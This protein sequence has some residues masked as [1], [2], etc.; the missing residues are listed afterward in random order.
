MKRCWQKVVA[1]LGMAWLYF[2]PLHAQT[3]DR[4]VQSVRKRFPTVRQLSTPEL[5][6]WLA[7]TN[8]ARPLLIDAREA[9]EF[10]VSHLQGAKN[11]RSVGQVR[12][13][14]VS[15]AGPIVVYCSVGYRSSALAAKLQAAGFTNVCNLEG[16]L[17]AWANEGRPVYR[18][19]TLLNPP[20]VHPYDTKWGELLRPE[21]R[22]PLK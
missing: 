22:A 8:L 16:S 1:C 10:E 14:V 12:A 5:A 19:D 20:L 18:G 6:A 7:T 11:L 17:F 9:K 2:T 21:L 3:L 13:L 15:N 4:L